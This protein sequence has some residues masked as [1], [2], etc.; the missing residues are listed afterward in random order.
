MIKVTATQDAKITFKGTEIE[1]SEVELRVVA[2]CP[3]SGEILQVYTIPYEIGGYEAGKEPLS[4]EGFQ[5]VQQNFSLAKGTDPE[6]YDD[7]S[8][9]VAHTKYI[10]Y[11]ESL[12]L[13]AE[14]IN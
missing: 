2:N 14:K 10:E 11:L 6:T 4:I 7:Q 12:G 8:M 5:T 9:D 1:I 13:E 3:A